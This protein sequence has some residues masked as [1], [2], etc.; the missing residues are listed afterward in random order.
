MDLIK[1][2]ALDSGHPDLITFLLAPIF[3]QAATQGSREKS[4]WYDLDVDVQ[5]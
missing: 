5:R 1:G 4:Q 3:K 2:Q